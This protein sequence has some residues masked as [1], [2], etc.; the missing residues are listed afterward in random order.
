MSADPAASGSHEALL[1]EAIARRAAGQIGEAERLCR[2][3][4][5]A[6]PSHARATHLLAT[7]ALAAGAPE[8]A[9]ARLRAAVSLDAENPLVLNDLGGVLQ[10]LNRFEEALPWHRM[11]LDR[12]PDMAGAAM[13]LGL[14]LDAL[15]RHGEAESVFRGVTE[16][17]PTLAHAWV[18]LGGTLLQQNRPDDAIRCYDR[19][20]A[21][22]PSLTQAELNRLVALLS[23][24]EFARAWPAYEARWR[25]KPDL[26]Q[27]R[28]ATRAPQ[29]RGEAAIAGTT[30]LLHAEQ[31]LGDTI[32][33]AR[34]APLVAARGIRVVLEVMP[35][36]K[37]LFTAMPGVASVLER[38]EALPDFSWQCPLMSL[39]L[40]FGTT[41]ATIPAAIPYIAADPARVAAWHGRLGPRRGARIGLAWSGS[42]D[43]PNDSNRSIALARLAP[44]LAQQSN[45]FHA[46]QKS[47][48]AADR[49][50]AYSFPSLAIHGD[51]LGDWG[52]TAAL[53]ALMDLVITVDSSVA[54][55]AGAQGRPTW[56]L[57]PFR[58]DWRWLIGRDDSPWYP[59]MRLFRQPAPGDWESVLAA[60]N[61]ALAVKDDG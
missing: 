52:D 3:I 37:P 53:M 36:M 28:A 21:L 11:A 8:E 50:T 17:H 54:H 40:A 5:S 39:P 7:L 1:R 12:A 48:R 35:G 22:D 25:L 16:R 34:Y 32:Q 61:K 44:L 19:A 38:G 26:R 41:L 49:A 51:A 46:V 15:D 58:A 20:L 30:I 33:F 14:V 43:H 31:G 6:A 57:L 47:L 42:P 56:L 24:G 29:W 4:L 27:S 13:N 60:V 10:I 59:G 18:R 23:A 2:A 9:L 45:A 55:L